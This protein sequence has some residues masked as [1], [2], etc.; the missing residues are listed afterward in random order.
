MQYLF[1]LL[2]FL[3][4]LQIF[5][6]NLFGVNIYP[7]DI[8]YYT[9]I[10]ILLI[11]LQKGN[12]KET[13]LLSGQNQIILIS[14]LLYFLFSV[15]IF[16]PILDGANS[17]Y[18]SVSV[19]FLIK[20][21]LFLIFFIS[22]LLSTKDIKTDFINK[23][24]S[25]FFTSIILHSI[26]SY[27]V[28]FN[29]YLFHIDIHTKFLAFFNVSGHSVGHGLLNFIYYPILRTTGFHWD[30][31]YF[32]VWGIIGIFY[33]LISK[34]KLWSKILFL[35]II[36]IPWIFTF[37]RSA[38]FGLII[39]ILIL[40]LVKHKKQNSLLNSTNIIAM[41]FV[42]IILIPFTILST[43]S[44]K[45]DFMKIFSSRLEISSDVHTQKHLKYPIMAAKA[46]AKDPIHFVFGYGNRNSGRA[47]ADE[48]IKLQ[49]DFDSNRAF[50]IESDIVRYPLNI[51]ILGFSLYLIF[52]VIILASIIRIFHKTNN[53]F[54]L[55]IFSA[56]SLIFFSGFF[57]AYNDSVWVWMIWIIAIFLLQNIEEQYLDRK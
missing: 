29:W 6:Y 9:L 55:F 42:M 56:I 16:V 57:Y 13:L 22:L 2:G 49:E 52:I 38:V 53:E 47:M 43:V 44:G 4:T 7:F 30:P 54:Y 45:A 35:L 15:N 19:K 3:S 26:Y 46:I 12:N 33:I 25:G 14:F 8:V 10:V 39:T 36:L 51:G 32:G 24:I 18:L 21:I 48:I 5:K 17:L 31:A 34:F 23:F 11:N 37:S 28:L 50:D 20:K 41:M 27:V 1:F 40:I